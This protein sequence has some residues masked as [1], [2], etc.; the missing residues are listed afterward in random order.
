MKN[1]A[2]DEISGLRNRNII[3]GEHS[4]S[5]GIRPRVLINAWARYFFIVIVIGFSVLTLA[6]WL[7]LFLSPWR[8]DDSTGGGIGR[9]NAGRRLPQPGEMCEG[10]VVSDTGVTARLGVIYSAGWDG[11]PSRVSRVGY[12][13]IRSVMNAS[14]EAAGWG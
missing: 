10:R 13:V 9:A 8:Y 2:K 3:Q 7:G 14:A 12:W 4:Q 6:F 11:C 1:E 5:I